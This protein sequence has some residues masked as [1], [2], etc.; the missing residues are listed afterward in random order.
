M[1][2]SQEPERKKR[3][4]EKGGVSSLHRPN[5]RLALAIYCSTQHWPA[6]CHRAQPPFCLD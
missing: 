5:H 6:A 1:K 3:T 2:T 4:R